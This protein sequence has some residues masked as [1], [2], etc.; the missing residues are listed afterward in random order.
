MRS[1]ETIPRA[2][3]PVDVEDLAEVRP[4]HRTEPKKREI[5]ERPKEQARSKSSNDILDDQRKRSRPPLPSSPLSQRK[6]Q[7]KE[8]APSIKIMIQRYNK[9]INEEGVC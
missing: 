5:R 8:T 6:P 2:V 4:D 3:I 1:G 9:K 7:P